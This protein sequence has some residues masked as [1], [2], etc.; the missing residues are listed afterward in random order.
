MDLMPGSGRSPGEGNGYPLQYYCL[1]NPM[2]RGAWWATVHGVSK[3]LDTTKRLNNN[4]YIYIYIKYI[5][6]IKKEIS[7][8][9]K[10][11]M[12]LEG[13]M[14]SEINWTKTNYLTCMWNL[15]TDIQTKTEL[16]TEWWVPVVRVG[17]GGVFEWVKGIK[18]YKL[19][20]I[21]Y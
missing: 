1:G 10:S 2:D 18:R 17:W 15:K 19:P 20:F 6:A 11:C 16:R 14:L 12:D 4:K 7:L 3:E 8:P 13:I 21:K 9:V 5:S